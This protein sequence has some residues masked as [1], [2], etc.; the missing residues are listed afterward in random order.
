M[1]SRILTRLVLLLG[2]LALPLGFVTVQTLPSQQPPPKTPEQGTAAIAASFDILDPQTTLVV[3]IPSELTGQAVVIITNIGGSPITDLN[4]FVALKDDSGNAFPQNDVKVVPSGQLNLE[5]HTPLVLQITL[6]LKKPFPKFEGKHSYTH[7]SLSGYLFFKAGDTVKQR[8]LQLVPFQSSPQVTRLVWFGLGAAVLIGAISLWCLRSKL[9]ERM[10]FP[11]WTTSS[12]VTNLTIIGTVLTA[13]TSAM[14]VVKQPH[15][16]QAAE[17]TTMSVL[18]GALVLIA[19]LAYNS[20]RFAQTPNPGGGAT[21]KYEGYVWL[22]IVAITFTLWGAFGQFMLVYYYF[23]EFANA[24]LISLSG[25]WVFQGGIVL[26]GLLLGLYAT[27][28]IYS[29]ATETSSTQHP[30]GS[31]PK[32]AGV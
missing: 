31:E 17:Y 30:G 12:W 24:H 7:Q 4:L 2:G 11:E 13:T 6:T 28:T 23:G 21:P 15:I 9:D 5:P 20:I 1:D 25:S 10:T 16:L 26:I 22:F 8:P 3:Q 14:G 29:Y 18:F 32:D 19:P 27:R